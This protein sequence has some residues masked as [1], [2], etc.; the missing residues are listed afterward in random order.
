MDEFIAAESPAFL[1]VVAKEM[2]SVTLQD[3]KSYVLSLGPDEV[4][5]QPGNGDFCLVAKALG[6][7]YGKVFS[8]SARNEYAWEWGDDYDIPLSPDVRIVADQF[9]EIDHQVH[10]NP[11]EV[12]PTRRDLERII[13]ELFKE[14]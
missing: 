6:Y 7:K 2:Y 11:H 8:V 5:G 14:D 10:A 3:L 12:L 9:D 4:A 13:P 1:G